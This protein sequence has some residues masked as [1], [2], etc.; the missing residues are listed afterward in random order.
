MPQQV[1][2]FTLQNGVKVP[3]IGFG[4]GTKWK[5]TGDDLDWNVIDAI[6]SAYKSGFHH[7][8]SAEV[9]NTE[10]ELGEA[11][12]DLDRGSLFITTKLRP[13][14]GTDIKP[15]FLSSLERLGV[16]YVDL[17]LLHA[18]FFGVDVVSQWKELEN[19]YDA[20]LVKSI[21][22]SNHRVSDLQA[23][24]EVARI[25][26]AVNEIEYHPYL[27]NQSPHIVEFCE[28]NGILVTAYSPLTPITKAK[29]KGPL[30][31][32]LER[33]AVKY[34][35]EQGQILLRWIYENNIL[36]IT[37][38]SKI[39]RDLQALD[40]FGFELEPPDHDDITET[41]S[42]FHYRQADWGVDWG[43][44]EDPLNTRGCCGIS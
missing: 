33:L 23:I 42:K 7:F 21:G 44:D 22:V 30:D 35:K 4:T 32:L 11:I 1:P 40:I 41:G 31:P 34:E 29:G 27:Q 19:L 8:D 38:S 2:D 24:L 14:L 16:D 12:S 37:T 10:N 15:H 26:P 6:G 20:G 9:Y 3:A 13:R 5:K 17:Y 43:D 28:K 18:P 25:K 39:D 36:P